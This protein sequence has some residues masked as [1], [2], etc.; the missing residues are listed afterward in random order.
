MN[1]KE[2][3][4]IKAPNK[5]EEINKSDYEETISKKMQQFRDNRGRRRG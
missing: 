3:S 2:K 4:E 1:P 5:G